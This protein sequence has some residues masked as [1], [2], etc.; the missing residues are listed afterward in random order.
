MTPKTMVQIVFGVT[1]WLCVCVSLGSAGFCEHSNYERGV[2]PL[3][4]HTTHCGG[5]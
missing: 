3:P 4:P 1:V 5:I 2:T